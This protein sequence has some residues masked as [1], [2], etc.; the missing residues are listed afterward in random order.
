MAPPGLLVRVQVPDDGRPESTT[1]PEG[2]AQVGWV[3]V[4]TVGAEGGVLTVTDNEEAVPSP[5]ELR[6]NTVIFPETEPVP[7][8]TD[9]LFVELVPVAPEGKVQTYEVA[10]A[11]TG[12]V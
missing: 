5:F 12:T 11:I 4:P 8:V 7:K 2:T 10:S 3:T 6:P 1:L 9:M